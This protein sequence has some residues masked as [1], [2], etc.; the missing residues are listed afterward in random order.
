MNETNNPK[1]GLS[2]TLAIVRR[3]EVHA[4]GTAPSGAVRH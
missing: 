2:T 3:L 4:R 1:L